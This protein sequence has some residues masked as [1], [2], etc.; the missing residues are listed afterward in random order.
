MFCIK[1]SKYKKFK[2]PKISYIL[3]ETLVLYM[4]KIPIWQK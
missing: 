2:G 3:N 1:Y 4:T